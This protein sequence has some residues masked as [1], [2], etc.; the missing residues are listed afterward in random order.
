MTTPRI[1][2]F[3]VEMIPSHSR[4]PRDSVPLTIPAKYGARPSRAS[5]TPSRKAAMAAIA[6][7]RKK[8]KV[9]GPPGRARMLRQSM[10]FSSSVE[11]PYQTTPVTAN[12]I[13]NATAMRAR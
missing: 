6:G 11:T 9:I 8:R 10:R 12:P 13:S 1:K 4:A 5:L 3:A 7:C 2:I